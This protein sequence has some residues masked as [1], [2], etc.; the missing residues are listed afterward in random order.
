[1]RISGLV[2]LWRGGVGSFWWPA[3]LVIADGVLAVKEELYCSKG[4]L[5]APREAFWFVL[6]GA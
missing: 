6:S 3:R 5:G 1:M 4:Y 2:F